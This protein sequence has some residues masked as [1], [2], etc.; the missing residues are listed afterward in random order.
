VAR[1]VEPAAATPAPARE[2]TPPP[3]AAEEPARLSFTFEHSLKSGSLQVWVDDALVL[4]EDVSGRVKREIAGIKFRKG[5]LASEM[6][7]V[8]GSRR[9]RVR[10]AWDDNVK[11]ETLRARFEPGERLRLRARLGGLAGLKKDL[12]LEW[13]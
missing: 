1:V 6:E 11:T 4:D 3:P 9:V 10:V 5:Q 2:E 13:R 8:P 12:S 7:V